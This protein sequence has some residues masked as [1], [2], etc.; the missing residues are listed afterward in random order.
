MVEMTELGFIAPSV[1]PDEEFQEAGIQSLDGQS[2]LGSWIKFRHE[3]ES[4][5]A[6]CNLGNGLCKQLECLSMVHHP[7]RDELVEE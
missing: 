7:L 3:L 2:H 1:G 4:W 5:E 6:S